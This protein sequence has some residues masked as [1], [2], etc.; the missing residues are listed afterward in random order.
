MSPSTR[1]TLPPGRKPGPSGHRRLFSVRERAGPSKPL[2]NFKV[3]PCHTLRPTFP[4][5]APSPRPAPPLA[6][7]PSAHASRP[8]G[9][10]P[11]HKSGPEGPFQS[12]LAPQHWGLGTPMPHSRLTLPPGC[13]LVPSGT[14]TQT[15]L[16]NGQGPPSHM[17]PSKTSCVKNLGPTLPLPSTLT[18]AWPSADHTTIAS[19]LPPSLGLTLTLG[20]PSRGPSQ[21]DWRH[22]PWDWGHGDPAPDSPCCQALYRAHWAPPLNQCRKMV[23]AL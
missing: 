9:A 5:P 6:A 7:Q 16:K 1:L 23:R 2:T 18:S 20:G 22:N 14:T 4:C 19:G 8:P 21:G 15:G 17:R 11:N 3:S 12:V 13:Q 10:N